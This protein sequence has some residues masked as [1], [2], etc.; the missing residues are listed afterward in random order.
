MP[1][2]VCVG[3]LRIWVLALVILLVPAAAMADTWMLPKIETYYSSDRRARLTV[4]PNSINPAQLGL[5]S[6]RTAKARGTAERLDVNGRWTAVWKRPLTNEV[7][8]ANVLVS[9]SAR[10]TIT[11][12]DWYSAGYGPNVVAIYGPSGSII[13]S[14]SLADILPS[15]YIKALPHSISSI[16]WGGEHHILEARD[17]LILKIAVPS[18]SEDWSK[19]SYV[20]LPV[21]L[22]TGKVRPSAKPEWHSALKQAF[23]VSKAK[24]AAEVSAEKLF[25]SPLKGPINSEEREWH[26]YLLEAFFRLDM[27]WKE[28]Y[29]DTNVLRLPGASDY[30][31]SERHLRDAMLEKESTAD[32]VMIASLSPPAHLVKVL[33]VIGQEVRPGAL[34]KARI[35]VAVPSSYRADVAAALAPTGA[36]FIHL[37]PEKP[38]PQRSERL[39]GR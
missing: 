21:Q 14:L 22:S 26:G 9:S 25:R 6:D 27:D 36:Q 29:P 33:K 28:G 1:T 31:L 17:E 4:F 12:N 23:S 18:A 19:G 10:Y 8:P 35:Y 7:S 24:Q 30:K 38:I 15:Y 37:D 16:W 34:G 39:A 11:F 2:V 13:R 3:V 20:D 5:S 32:V